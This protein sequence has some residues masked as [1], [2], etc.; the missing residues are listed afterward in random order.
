MKVGIMVK[1]KILIIALA[2]SIISVLSAFPAF[3]DDESG[4]AYIRAE[5]LNQLGLLKGIGRGDYEMLRAPTRAECAVMVVRLLGKEKEALQYGG[6]AVPFRDVPAWAAK[7]I[8][9]AYEN[10]IAKGV[11]DDRFAPDMAVD[12]VQCVTFL[13]RALNYSDDAGDFTYDDAEDF[14]DSVG[15]LEGFSGGG[16]FSRADMIALSWNALNLRPKG[17]ELTLAERLLESG[18][19]KNAGWEKAC[20]L[21]ALSS[22]QEYGFEWKESVALQTASLDQVEPGVKNALM[23]LPDKIILKTPVGKEKSYA[24]Y[25]NSIFGTMVRYAKEFQLTYYAGSG[26]VGIDVDYTKG[27][28]SMSYL[29]NPTVPVSDDIKTLAMK[30]FDIYMEKFSAVHSDYELVRA[31]HDYIADTLAY[32]PY[33]KPGSDDLDGPLYTG[34]AT[35]G[36]YAALFQFLAGLSGLD[37]ETVYGVSK[38]S[39]GGAEGHVWNMVRVDGD[40]YHVDVTWD[41]PVTDTG[42]GIVRYNYFLLSDNEIAADHTWNRGFYPSAPRSWN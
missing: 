15:L 19:I 42:V 33:D 11:S 5:Q 7:Y 24:D 36:G 9:Y 27:F 1:R 20:A 34:K 4:N 26:A 41:D 12:S 16:K 40:W 18:A 21:D 38:N 39:K 22:I 30:G 28:M 2:V 3:A 37:V 35:C 17:D 6:E 14:A 25:I 29:R 13:L 31:I 8:S 10:G 23:A 32:D